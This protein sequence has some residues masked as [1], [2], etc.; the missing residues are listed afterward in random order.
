MD[1]WDHW[2]HFLLPVLLAVLGTGQGFLPLVPGI[3]LSSG[4]GLQQV[5]WTCSHS[6]LVPCSSGGGLGTEESTSGDW[7]NPSASFCSLGGSSQLPAA[8]DLRHREQEQP[9]D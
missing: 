2:P 4:E 5:P 6:F 1:G 8:G 7:P 3:C 9:G